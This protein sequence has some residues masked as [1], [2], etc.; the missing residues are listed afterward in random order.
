M[1]F[2]EPARGLAFRHL[3]D[4]QFA[5]YNIVNITYYSSNISKNRCA[6]YIFDDITMCKLDLLLI[7]TK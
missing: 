6:L 2:L 3:S 1:Q 4:C 5:L 7:V